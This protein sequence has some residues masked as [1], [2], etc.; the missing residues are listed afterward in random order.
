MA[1]FLDAAKLPPAA[2]EA[3]SREVAETGAVH[4][5]ELSRDDW[6]RLPAWANLREMERRRVLNLVPP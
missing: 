1:M 5:Q 3:L 2:V 6:A 4:V